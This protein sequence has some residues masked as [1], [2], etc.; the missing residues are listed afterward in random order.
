MSIQKRSLRLFLGCFCL[1]VIILASASTALAYNEAPMLKEKVAAGELPEVD[2]RLPKNPLVIKP[3]REV[4]KYGGTWHKFTTSRD[5]ANMRM[6]MYGASPVRWIDDGL[7]IE[8]NWLDEWASNEEKTVWTLHIREGIRWSDGAQF[9]TADFMFWWNDMVLNL[10]MSDPVPDMFIAGGETAK[11]EALDEYTLRISYAGPAPLLIER[12]AMWPNYGIGERL[13]A[14]AHYLKQ[15]HPS[16]NSEYKDFE[17]FEEKMEWWMNP[18]CPVITEWMPVQHMPSMRMVLE[19]NPYYYA[20]DTEGN[21]L[22]Y[23]DRIDITF[24]EDD[25]VVKLKLLNGESEMQLR[26]Y[27]SLTDMAMFR[28]AQ[29]QMGYQVYLWDCGDGSGPILY[30]NW[31]HPDPEK[32]ELYHNQKFRAALSHAI[33]RPKIQKTLF[34]GLGEPTSATLSP[35]AIEYH[36]TEE[37]KQIYKEWRDAYVEYAPDK[38]KALLDEIGVVDANG[39]GWRDMPNGKNLSIRIDYNAAANRTD[40]QI[41]EMVKTEW[42]LLGIRTVMNPMD[43]SQLGV[44]DST[45]TFDMHNSWEIGDGPNHLVFPQWLVPMDL[46]RWAPLNGSWYA[47]QGTAKEGTELD[48]DPRDRN[49]PREKPAPGGPIDRLQQL[50][51]LAKREPDEAKRDQY[52][53]DMIKIHIEDGPFMFGTIANYPIPVV[54]S[55]K[56]HNVPEGKD[57]AMGGFVKPWIMVYPGITNPAQ[58]WLEQ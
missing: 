6:S 42:E 8:P 25:E 16:Y 48:K 22:P 39:D 34:F 31:N 30:P 29:N 27:L 57:L 2:Q 11:V 3:L 54:V 38:S 32:R 40:I 51:S 24:V 58:Y 28:R 37:G 47:V 53:F 20:V 10:E 23:I 5:W 1:A 44:M 18:E 41:N 17:V 56:M 55:N 50:Y 13:I 12:L 45:A 46:S 33:N 35:K 26:P 36:R 15:F 49:P 7:G 4:G 9:T 21:Q 52:V 19:R 14:P 43:G